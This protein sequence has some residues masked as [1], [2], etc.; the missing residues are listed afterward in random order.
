MKKLIGILFVLGVV[1]ATFWRM[2]THEEPMHA[3]DYLQI[4]IENGTSGKHVDAI[5]AFKK[6]LKE[7]PNYI[8]AYLSLG[9]AYGNTGR[10]KESIA[11]YKEGIQLNPRHQK[12]PQMEMNIAWVA[13]KA[14]DNKTAVLYAKKAIQSFTNRNDYAGVA[15]AGARLRMIEQKSESI[16]K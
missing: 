6:A 4:G 2:A 9:N 16:I 12:V 15:R 3:E 11:A 7:N 13:H 5:E 1:S 14:N 10:Y 8:D